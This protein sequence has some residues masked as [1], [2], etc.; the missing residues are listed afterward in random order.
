MKRASPHGF[1]LL[2]LMVTLTI[3]AILIVLGIPSYE[4]WIVNS[5]IRTATESI[6]N[7]L[8]FARNEAS[9]RATNVRFQLNSP[10]DGADW[11]VCLLPAS[12]TSAAAVSTC[13]DPLASS[14]STLQS[15]TGKDGTTGVLI[16]ATTAIADIAPGTYG[17]SGAGITGGVPAGI[18]FNPL[19]RPS[20]YNG[21]SIV[22]ID[23]NAPQ[24]NSRRLVTTISAGG[25]VNM[26]D[27]QIT[28]GTTTGPQGCP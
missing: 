19:G 5:R 24:A 25:M 17:G 26:C 28:F 6:Q 23:A 21:T 8:R 1:S 10:T 3:L 2:E 9:Q 7:G 13:P 15:F 12:A 16:G 27:P 20:D 22:R 11:T 18:T 14:S 4:Q